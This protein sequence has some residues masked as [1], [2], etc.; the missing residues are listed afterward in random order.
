MKAEFQCRKREVSFV[1]RRLWS[2]NRETHRVF[3]HPP[4]LVLAKSSV[5]LHL[6]VHWACC[7]YL[8][9]S[10]GKFLQR[11]KRLISIVYRAAHWFLVAPSYSQRSYSLLIVCDSSSLRFWRDWF[12]G[13]WRYFP[14]T[15]AEDLTEIIRDQRYWWT[16]D[17]LSGFV[18]LVFSHGCVEVIDSS[19]L[20]FPRK[21]TSISVNCWVL[22]FC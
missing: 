8:F 11:R 3:F 17:A 10:K 12:C 14:N 19:D 13:K 5:Q 2:R 18:A 1:L 9:G 16:F 20:L 7:G 22:F 4:G 21:C 6:L 15:P